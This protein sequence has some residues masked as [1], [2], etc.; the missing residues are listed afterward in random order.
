M[1]LLHSVPSSILQTA[2]RGE[3]ALCEYVWNSFEYIT[4]ATCGVYP[5]VLHNQRRYLA[6]RWLSLALRSMTRKLNVKGHS[7]YAKFNSGLVFSF[8]FETNIFFFIVAK[9]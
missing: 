3:K 7:R 1:N 2:I 4:R 8:V 5:V 6:G 9:R